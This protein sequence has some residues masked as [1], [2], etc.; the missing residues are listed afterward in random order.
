MGFLYGINTNYQFM[1]HGG[2]MVHQPYYLLSL[3][4]QYSRLDKNQIHFVMLL[5]WY[6]SNHT[7]CYHMHIMYSA[8]ILKTFS[9]STY[10]QE[11]KAHQG[12]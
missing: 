8:T 12:L 3:H 10:Y 2:K 6:K 4:C 5:L 11:A 1:S 7:K 9:A